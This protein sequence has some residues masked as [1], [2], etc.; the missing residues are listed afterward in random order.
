MNRKWILVVVALAL[1][2]IAY[3]LYAGHSTPKG[4]PP[5]TSF[6]GDDVAPLKAAFNNSADSIRVLLLLSPT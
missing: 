6:S 2:G 5:L 3:Y 4:Q 1:F